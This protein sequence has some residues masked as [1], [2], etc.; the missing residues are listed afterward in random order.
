VPVTAKQPGGSD[1]IGPLVRYFDVVVIVVAAPIMLLI[2]VPALGYAVGAGA[3]ILLR[4][5]GVAVDSAA[6]ASPDMSRAVGL[7]LGFMLGRLFL[8]ALAVI[9]AR[10]AGTRDDGL[11]AL[12]VIVFAF[13]ASM[14][15]SAVTRPRKPATRSTPRST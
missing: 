3:W 6:E 12:A 14:A 9:L 1:S 4:A 5:V 7:R 13:T 11:T 10:K 8:L 2:G 15:L